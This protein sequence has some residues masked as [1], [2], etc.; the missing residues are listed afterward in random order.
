M[1]KQSTRVIQISR[2]G[3][4]EVL[5]F[6]SLPI[7]V[8]GPGEIRL[9]VRA[10]GLNRA[11][12]MIRENDYVEEPT[13]PGRLGY[14]ASGIVDAV[15]EGIATLTE[16]DP[17]SIVPAFSLNDYAMYGETVLAPGHAAVPLPPGM[18]FEQGASIW[19]MFLTAYGALVEE[20]KVGAGDVVLIDA[21]S[22][23]VGLAA[24][25]LTKMLGATPV[26]LTRTSAKR[27]RLLDAGAAHVIATEEQDVVTAVRDFTGGKG[28]RIAFDAVGGSLLPKLVASLTSGGIVL[29]YGDLSRE[30]IA[31]PV[32]PIVGQAAT[33]KGYVVG[34]L[35]RDPL[36]LDIAMKFILA[37]FQSGSLKPSIDREFAFD[38]IA[39]AHRY[40]E[41]GQQFGKIVIKL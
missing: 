2:N 36:R 31:M 22:S 23:S 39:A 41:S 29:V 4:P 17:V 30:P 11:D 37:G 21:A 3:G 35:T 6:I 19:A 38:D 13:F 10:I 1:S 18:T 5:E 20:A 24:I 25:Q 16:G 12:V 26:A 40:L 33:I 34:D 32:L 15:G 14:E 27:Q 28:A 7:P 8:P 9:K